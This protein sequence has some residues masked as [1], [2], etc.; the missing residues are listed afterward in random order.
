MAQT[1]TPTVFV[2]DGEAIDYTPV[3]A[4]YAG[5]VVLL[6]DIPAIAKTDIAANKLGALATEGIFAAP[7]IT[8]AVTVGAAVYWSATADPVGGTAGTGAAT[9]VQLNNKLMGY[10]ILAAASGDATVLVKL[11]AAK[12][13]VS[14]VLPTATVAAAGTVQGDATQIATGLTLVT[15]A[16]D[17]KGVLLP[18]ASAGLI[19]YVKSSVANKILKVW[20]ATG[21][22]INALSA[23]AA[24]SL[25][26][27]PTPVILVA[28]DATTWYSFPLVPS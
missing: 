22:A 1:Q 26:S 2:Q 18:A 14:P 5:D 17:A 21:D 4:V 20:P 24:L 10:A 11:G 6:G 25:A 7:K 13:A 15:G 19:C 12:A 3:A 8:G 16:D 27:G 28:L 23:N 9:T